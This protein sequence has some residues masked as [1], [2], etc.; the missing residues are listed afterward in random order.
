MIVAIGGQDFQREVVRVQR[1][2]A[3]DDGGVQRGGTGDSQATESGAGLGVDVLHRVQ[4]DIEVGR[5][6]FDG[7]ILVRVLPHHIGQREDLILPDQNLAIARQIVLPGAA[8]RHQY[9]RVHMRAVVITCTC[10]AETEDNRRNCVIMPLLRRFD[11]RL[12][13]AQVD[14][15][16][17]MVIAFEAIVQV[18][19]IG[20][21][22][23]FV[24]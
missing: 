18:L 12:I 4:Y 15:G 5:V 13:G 23:I 7:D 11:P 24:A 17:C 21:A 6:V 3:I 2:W 14:E 10:P 19:R 16:Q 20:Q 22:V 1:H 8:V 9:R